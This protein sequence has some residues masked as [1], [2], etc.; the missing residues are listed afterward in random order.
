MEDGVLTPQTASDAPSPYLDPQKD[1]QK[2]RSF[3]EYFQTIAKSTQT[4][5]IGMLSS[6]Y[7][8]MELPSLVTGKSPLAMQE[9][10]MHF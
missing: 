1:G 7:T 2:A 8:A 3:L 5:I 9:S 6:L 10:L 4:F